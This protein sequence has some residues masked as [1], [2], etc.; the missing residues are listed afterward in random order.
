MNGRSRRLLY[1]LL[2]ALLAGCGAPPLLP[3]ATS[4]RVTALGE[5]AFPERLGMKRATV[6]SYQAVNNNLQGSLPSDLDVMEKV[7]D[8]AA[9][10]IVVEADTLNYRF[11][12]TKGFE[13]VGY[14][15]KDKAYRFF[16]TGDARE[17]QYASPYLDMPDPDSGSGSHLRSFVEWGFSRY[18]A[19]LKVLD[20]RSHGHGP[21]G[22]ADDFASKS[23]IFL[24]ELQHA[25]SKGLEG[26]LDVLTTKACLMASVETGF[27]LS[28]CTK[29]LVGSE[30]GM[31]TRAKMDSLLYRN[32]DLAAKASSPQEFAVAYVE[33]AMALQQ[34][35]RRTA[36]TLS[37]ID[38]G[39]LKAVVAP[40]R[41][42]GA[43]LR[44]L[45][46]E[47][48]P[49]I[50]AAFAKSRNWG[51]A[52]TQTD[53]ADLC[54]NLETLG[55][56]RLARAASEVRKVVSSAVLVARAD[57]DNQAGSHGLTILTRITTGDDAANQKLF[58]EYKRTA[59][60][61]ETGWS[62][63]LAALGAFGPLRKDKNG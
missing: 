33:K 40:M 37:A 38:L 14:R 24:P 49:E 54:A 60:D 48:K 43:A 51:S 3:G 18:P 23:R 15:N 59:F 22:I 58:A 52:Q 20:I 42:V 4:D 7:I 45:S 29:V 16:V 56:P 47:R 17:G 53:L 13:N 61:R 44:A 10:N 41:E 55:D 34:P 35:D 57:A 5:G 6:L 50:A 39:K 1:L 46:P 11:D 19:R 63:I 30:D 31:L 9:M 12:W 26:Q 2:P 62:E 28:D 27:Q 36:T 21:L 32:L 25:I 8:P